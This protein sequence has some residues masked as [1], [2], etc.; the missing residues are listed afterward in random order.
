[1]TISYADSYLF[2]VNEYAQKIFR[3]LKPLNIAPD[4]WLPAKTKCIYVQIWI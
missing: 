4:G 2:P 1:M 3:V